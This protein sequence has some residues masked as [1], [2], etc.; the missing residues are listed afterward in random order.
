M[1]YPTWYESFDHA[2]MLRDCFPADAVTTGTRET[3]ANSV[4]SLLASDV[5]D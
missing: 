4:S 1:S 2:A 5:E 3:S